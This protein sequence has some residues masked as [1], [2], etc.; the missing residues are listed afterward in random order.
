[1]GCA[2]IMKFNKTKCKMLHVYWRNPKHKNKLSVELAGN[3]PAEKDF[4]ILVWLI[5]KL[6]MTQQC[7]L[8]AQKANCIL[9]CIKR[10]VASSEIKCTLSKFVDHR[11]LHSAVD[12]TEGR[13]VIQGDLDK[14]E[15]WA[16]E[17]LMK[18]N[19]SKGKVLHLGWE[20]PT[21]RSEPLTTVRQGGQGGAGK[22]RALATRVEMELSSSAS[23][24]SA[25]GEINGN[26]NGCIQLAAG[27]SGV[28]QGSV[29][30]PVL[31]NIFIDDLDEG[32][33]SIISKFADDTK[34]GGSVN[35]LEGRRAPQRDLGRLESR[36]DSNG[37]RFNKAKCRVLHFGHKNILQSYRLGTEWLES[38]QRDQPSYLLK[39]DRKYGKKLFKQLIQDYIILD[40]FIEEEEKIN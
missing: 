24:L 5:E 20:N 18:F 2:N 22:K 29:L 38:S 26:N 10:S 35:L 13:D 15:Q 34:L 11:K 23:H 33:E 28:P 21:H 8:A 17:H 12:T 4:G 7:A 39:E 14:L 37:M 30:D 19:K 32:I 25:L 31:F 16:Y 1:M 27:T 9:G 40:M 3:S 36:A 6:D